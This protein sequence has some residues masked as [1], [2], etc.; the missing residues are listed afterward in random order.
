M[1]SA[2]EQQPTGDRAQGAREVIRS[3]EE[4]RVERQWRDAYRVR[5]TKRIVTEER[6]ITVPVRREELVI[7]HEPITEETWRDGPPGPAE[8][9]VLTLREEQIEVVTR[10]VPLER[11]RIS[12]DRTTERLRID[13]DLR[14]E[15]VR[16]EVD[17]RSDRAR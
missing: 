11:V 14:R 13:E 2:S 10:V 17:G 16:V 7:E 9:L 4:L 1:S 12:V 3:E 8:D 6:T 5:V 15:Q